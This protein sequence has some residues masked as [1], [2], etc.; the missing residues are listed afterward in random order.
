VNISNPNCPDKIRETMTNNE[1]IPGLSKLGKYVLNDYSFHGDWSK[2]NILKCYHDHNE[3]VKRNV[4]ADRLLVIDLTKTENK[5]EIICPFLGIPIPE[6][7]FPHSNERETFRN[8]IKQ[9]EA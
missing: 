4:P 1:P 6:F 8:V 9:L 5:W 2:E 3:E 7:P